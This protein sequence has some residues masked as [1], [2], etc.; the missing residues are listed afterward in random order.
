MTDT[1]VV[2]AVAAVM[3]EI[4]AVGKGDRNTA[5]N[6]SFRGID[7]VLNAVGPALR[8]HGVVVMP[9]ELKSVQ[10]ETVEVGQKRTPMAHVVIRQVYRWYGPAGDYLDAEVPGEAMDAG[11]K[12]LS[13]AMSVAFR[14]CLIQGLALPTGDPDPDS[15]SYERA[16]REP[17]PLDRGK[18]TR[19]KRKAPVVDE[20]STPDPLSAIRARI[21][22]AAKPL[23]YDSK[24]AIEAHYAQYTQGLLFSDAGDLELTAYLTH[25]EHEATNT[26]PELA[27]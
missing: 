24:E 19:E 21:F 4:K 18:L 10:T 3:A 27:L 8:K 15:Q 26:E 14:T 13:K 9:H 6:F 22:A 5:Q 16:A 23:G 20:W 7:S 2:Q 11:D 17:L 1:T 25:L 12:G